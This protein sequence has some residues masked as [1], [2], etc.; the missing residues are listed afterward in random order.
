MIIL[1]SC[2]HKTGTHFLKKLKKKIENLYPEHEFKMD[3]WSHMAN[4]LY[5]KNDLKIIHIVRNPLEIIRSGYEYHKKCK[6]KWCTDKNK[7]TGADNIKFN[8]NNKSYQYKINSLSEEDGINF[9]MNGRSYYTIENMY[10][11]KFVSYPNCLTLKM[12]NIN[13]N[14]S[15]SIL[16]INNFL[17]I[18]IPTNIVN[19][20]KKDSSKKYITCSDYNNQFEN[21]F[22]PKN[23]KF[24][25]KLF[26][27][28]DFK[29]YDYNIYKYNT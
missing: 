8:F 1:L 16:K 11:A 17:K 25:F 4:D 29:L 15:K 7:E 28:L 22:T 9:E 20:L 2:Y 21:I 14:L 23:L 6:E 3:Q 27:H 26:K 24:F 12:E 18:S 13:S 19:E 10:N 5:Q